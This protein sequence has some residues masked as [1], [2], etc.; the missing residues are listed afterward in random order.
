MSISDSGATRVNEQTNKTMTLSLWNMHSVACER[1]LKI[2]YGT[3]RLDIKS[4]N[5]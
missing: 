2:Y 1:N 4:Q 5:I 3:S